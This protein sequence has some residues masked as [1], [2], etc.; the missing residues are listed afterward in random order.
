MLGATGFIGLP[1]R[2][3]IRGCPDDAA[4]ESLC[5]RRLELLKAAAAEDGAEYFTNDWEKATCTD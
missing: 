5:G 3:E 4:I 1:Y 2:R